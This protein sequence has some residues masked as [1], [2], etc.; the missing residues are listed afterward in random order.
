MIILSKFNKKY[1]LNL[2]ITYHNTH[3]EFFTK[4]VK[5]PSQKFVRILHTVREDSQ[6][7]LASIA[8]LILAKFDENSHQILLGILTKFH[9]EPS[10]NSLK[11][12]H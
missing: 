7:N 3:C 1:S 2:V 6:R 4:S 10:S 9:E 8:T 12:S 11:N 5:N